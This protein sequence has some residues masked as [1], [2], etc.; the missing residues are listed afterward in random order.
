MNIRDIAR[1]ADVSPGTVSKVL[2]NYSDISET[3]RRRVLQVIQENQYDS[4]SN[5]RSP[6]S[7]NPTVGLVL[8]GVYNDIYNP[9]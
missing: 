3:T 9:G 6:K 8:E 5:P 2:N 1:L 4:R 7:G